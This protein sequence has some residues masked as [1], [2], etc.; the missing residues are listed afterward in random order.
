MVLRLILW[1][2]LKRSEVKFLHW[3]ELVARAS[4]TLID[5]RKDTSCK[6]APAKNK[7]VL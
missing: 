7:V 6:L 5:K 2:F 4:K 1:E 3:R